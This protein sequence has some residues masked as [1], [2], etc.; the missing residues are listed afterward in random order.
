MPQVTPT[1]KYILSKR[2]KIIKFLKEEG[3]INADIAL[4]FNIDPSSIT[5]ILQTEKNYKGLVKEKLKN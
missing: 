1:Q 3:Y 2:A 4:I 5:R